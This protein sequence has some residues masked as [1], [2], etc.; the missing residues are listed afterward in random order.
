[1]N[2][3]L[4]GDQ[5]SEEMKRR[6]FLLRYESITSDPT[7]TVE[8]LYKFAEMKTTE[9]LMKW[10]EEHVRPQRGEKWTT[11]A[12]VERTAVVEQ[13]CRPLLVWLGLKPSAIALTF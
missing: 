5:F 10:L 3:V 4:V 7:K 2:N 1:M 9:G 11:Q 13:T 8:N 12:P 6:Y